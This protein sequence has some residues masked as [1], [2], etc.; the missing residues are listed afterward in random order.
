MDVLGGLTEAVAVAKQAAGIPKDE[1]V[2][3][4]EVSRA[5]TSPLALLGEKRLVVQ[6]LCCVQ[7]TWHGLEQAVFAAL[8][9]LVWHSSWWVVNY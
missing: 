3:V 8:C 9:S 5:Q 2:T 6:L 4:V 7:C 1:N